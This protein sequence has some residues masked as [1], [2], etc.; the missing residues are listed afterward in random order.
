MD[1]A[2]DAKNRGI[3]VRPF[4]NYKIQRQCLAINE[5]AKS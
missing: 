5:I 1:T 2:S 4:K 3:Y